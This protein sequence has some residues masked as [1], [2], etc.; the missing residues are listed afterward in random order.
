MPMANRRSARPRKAQD[1][2]PETGSALPMPDRPTKRAPT[3]PRVVARDVVRA[4]LLS[5]GAGMIECSDDD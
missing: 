5:V 3:S 1:I 4:A 2:V